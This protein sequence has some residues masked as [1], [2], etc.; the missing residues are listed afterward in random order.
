M[1]DKFNS[2]GKQTKDRFVP[3]KSQEGGEREC[4][5][6]VTWTRG[7]LHALGGKYSTGF[8]SSSALTL[9]GNR[10]NNDSR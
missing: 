9:T 5:S 2:R 6:V 8:L 7:P 3:Q 4:V 1:S 10:E